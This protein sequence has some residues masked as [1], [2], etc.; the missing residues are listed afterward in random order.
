MNE[1]WPMKFSTRKCPKYCW[2]S[3]LINNDDDI[4]G[5]VLRSGDLIDSPGCVAVKFE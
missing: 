5:L 3:N 2:T 4:D 1:F